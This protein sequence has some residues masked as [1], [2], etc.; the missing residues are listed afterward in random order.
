VAVVIQKIQNTSQLP[1][2]GRWTLA[3]VPASLPADTGRRKIDG[4]E[5]LQPGK[6]AATG[7]NRSR[8]SGS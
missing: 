3:M 5:L 6:K 2:A 1:A 4:A 7:T 8:S